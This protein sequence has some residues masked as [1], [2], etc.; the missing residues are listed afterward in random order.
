[1]TDTQTN[2]NIRYANIDSFAQHDLPQSLALLLFTQRLA[3]L[4]E[5]R[6]AMVVHVLDI[7]QDSPAQYDRG[8]NCHQLIQFYY[9]GAFQTCQRKVRI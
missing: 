4:V 6:I 1:M 7:L 2:D 8:F 9:G 5:A 3:A